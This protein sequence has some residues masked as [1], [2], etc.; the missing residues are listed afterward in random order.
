MLTA[1]TSHPGEVV[2]D[3]K[4]WMMD[5]ELLAQ[6]WAKIKNSDNTQI[7]LSINPF[8]YTKLQ[9]TQDAFPEAKALCLFLQDSK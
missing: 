4:E 5:K 8:S 9:V 3:M 2:K 6:C 7:L 1:A